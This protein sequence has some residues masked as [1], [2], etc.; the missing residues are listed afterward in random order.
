MGGSGSGCT[1]SRRERGRYPLLALA[2]Y[3]LVPGERRV[4]A[5][6]HF[7]RAGFEALRGF[8]ALAAPGERPRG[9]PRESGG[10]QR[11]EIE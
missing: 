11:I 3:A 7:R 5:L 4:R 8:A 10:R 2:A 1:M 6:G 9:G